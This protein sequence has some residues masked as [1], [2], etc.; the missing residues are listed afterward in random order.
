MA[1]VGRAKYTRA[2]VYFACPTITIAKIRDYS[3]SKNNVGYLETKIFIVFED[4]PAISKHVQIFYADCR[5]RANGKRKSS[6]NVIRRVHCFDI[7][8]L[9]RYAIS[10]SSHVHC[11]IKLKTQ[12][13][14]TRPHRN[15]RHKCCLKCLTIRIKIQICNLRNGVFLTSWPGCIPCTSHAEDTPRGPR[16]YA[17]RPPRR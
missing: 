2:R 17:K 13:N 12:S 16:L 1:I 7:G 4:H 3:Q 6:R 14:H 9:S 15:K 11:R 8:L 5:K 10:S